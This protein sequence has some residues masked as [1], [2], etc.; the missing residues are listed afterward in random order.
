MSSG[1]VVGDE[2][3]VVSF[4]V[5][6]IPVPK[7]RPR[8]GRGVTFT[9]ERTR[10]YEG[11]VR[12]KALDAKRTAGMGDL[13]TLTGSIGVRI[14]LFLNVAEPYAIV[15]VSRIPLRAEAKRHPDLDNIAKSILDGLTSRRFGKLSIPG[16]I[17]DD[18]QVAR[19]VVELGD[20]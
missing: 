7:G 13:E 17:E 5:P 9:P 6:G 19:L 3:F 2:I 10:D 15:A 8:F 14:V 18:A 16:L 20:S 12:A 4:P 11:W 1:L